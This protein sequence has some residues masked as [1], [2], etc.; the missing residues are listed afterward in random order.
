MKDLLFALCFGGFA[1]IVAFMTLGCIFC[2]VVKKIV[3]F[4][5][6]EH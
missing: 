5:E 1:V 3:E 6:D 4:D 2:V